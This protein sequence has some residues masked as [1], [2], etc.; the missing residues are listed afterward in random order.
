MYAIRS[1][2]AADD[3]DNTND[4]NRGLFATY[5]DADLGG[6]CSGSGVACHADGGSWTRKWKATVTANDGSECA[7][8]HGDFTSGWN[9]GVGHAVNPTRGT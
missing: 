1:Y 5:V 7:N 4:Q 6:S 9:A 2:Y 3:A 8:C